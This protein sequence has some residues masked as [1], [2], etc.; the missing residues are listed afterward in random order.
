MLTFY[1]ILYGISN[2]IRIYHPTY[3]FDVIC[4]F[5]RSSMVIL[6]EQ[7]HFMMQFDGY[8]SVGQQ[9]SNAC[10]FYLEFQ[11]IFIWYKFVR[12]LFT[13]G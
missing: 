13:S 8:F 12:Y 11:K 4:L 9:L 6:D 3:K 2:T 5:I 1:Y 10:V 7:L